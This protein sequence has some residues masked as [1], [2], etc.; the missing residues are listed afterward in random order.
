MWNRPWQDAVAT[1]SA[2]LR[3]PINV[4]LAD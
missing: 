1:D 2:L 4:K 3:Q